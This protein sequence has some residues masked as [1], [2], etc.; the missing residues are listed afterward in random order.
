MV[1]LAADTNVWARALL[2]D[3]KAQAGKAKAALTQAR[4]TGGIFVPLL[5]LAE[6]SWV[7]RSRWERQKVIDTLDGMLR[8][9][10]VQVESPA[11]ARK[12]LDAARNGAAGFADH[13]IA[14]ISFAAGAN[15]ILTFDKAFAR[16]PRVRRLH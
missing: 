16:Q 4:S 3:D 7:L 6:L 10:G 1:M 13:L 5:V 15:E 2:E 12:A 11:L 14:E 9:R 8:T